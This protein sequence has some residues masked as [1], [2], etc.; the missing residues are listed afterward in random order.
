[1]QEYSWPLGKQHPASF[2][3]GLAIRTS[4]R[5]MVPEVAPEATKL[6]TTSTD[7]PF[8]Y[9]KPEPRRRITQVLRTCQSD[10]TPLLVL[11]LHQW[12]VP[13]ISV[14]PLCCFWVCPGSA[15]CIDN[16]WKKL[17]SSQTTQGPTATA[18]QALPSKKPVYLMAICARICSHLWRLI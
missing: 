8:N 18:S 12:V 10:F 9:R 16:T 5:W 6:D 2:G 3:Y 15:S 13:A 7:P 1:M 14:A 11:T 4:P 17:W